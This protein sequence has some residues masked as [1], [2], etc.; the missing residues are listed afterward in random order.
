MA[1]YLLS[2]NAENMELPDDVKNALPFNPQTIVDARVDSGNVFLIKD[3]AEEIPLGNL[4]GAPGKDGSNVVPTAQAIAAV[5]A[6]VDVRDY[7]QSGET[8]VTDGSAAGN[9]TAIIQRAVNAVNALWVADGRPRQIFFPDGTYWLSDAGSV[10]GDAAARYCV[11]WMS[12]VGI[13]TSSFR[14][15][16]F[17]PPATASAFAAAGSW[18]NIQDVYMDAH[19]VDGYKQTNTVVN[20]K[21]KG[22]FIQGLKNSHW[23]GP[24]IKNCFSTGW[25]NDY[26]Q[27]VTGTLYANGN[28]RG[29]LERQL[30]VAGNYRTATATSG[31]ATLTSSTI[32]AG[33]A[34]RPIT[35]VGIPAGTYVGTVVE[36]VSFKLTSDPFSQVDVL[37]TASG[38]NSYRLSF[39]PL[40]SSGCSGVGIGTGRFADESFDL[41]CYTDGNGFHGTF[42]ETQGSESYSYAA[43]SQ[44]LYVFASNNYVGFR[45]CGSNGLE[46][47]LTT[48]G[49][50]YAEVLHAKTILNDVL[51]TNGKCTVN[52]VGAA[53]TGILFGAGTLRGPYTFTGEIRNGAGNGVGTRSDAALPP[54]LTLALDIH[55]NAGAAV[56]L[57][58]GSDQLTVRV[59]EWGNGGKGLALKGTGTANDLT[60]SNSDFRSGGTLIEQTL[61]GDVRVSD[62]TRGIALSKPS[63]VIAASSGTDGVALTWSS[64]VLPGVT[65][66]VIQYRLGGATSWT[67]WAHTASATPA[68]TLT[69]LKKGHTYD[70]QVA[71]VTGST[72][73]DFTTIVRGIAGVA[74]VID[75]FNRASGSLAGQTAPDGT[76]NPTWTLNT[77]ASG[78]IGVSSS[79]VA[80]PTSGGSVVA[81]VPVSATVGAVQMKFHAVKTDVPANRRHGLVFAYQDATNYF[82][83]DTRPTSTIL[84]L[85]LRKSIAGTATIISQYSRPAVAG[86]VARIEF[87]TV[88]HR[89]AWYVNEEFVAAVVDADFTYTL[90]AGMYG[91]FTTDPLSSADDFMA[92]I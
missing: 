28:G 15:V 10:P 36:G 51:G 6:R 8:L 4:K 16:I 41:T 89:I 22:W 50:K 47:V 48:R 78:V 83:C 76:T 45:D 46:T 44:R 3:N 5:I 27:N 63:G 20:S 77:T 90:A 67:T 26:L 54:R 62:T 61:T 65:D 18:G 19:V 69:G 13:G 7:V 30:D 37:V 91:E 73:S 85:G 24:L 2:V 53:G 70:F 9:N 92:W 38:S 1:N 84:N 55:D 72:T 60:I 14:G 11:R 79:I 74:N 59:R 80:K 82:R 68:A 58:K 64:P 39:D 66:Y 31:S 52:L 35:G 56:S 33:D 86:D 49:N 42:T 88:T 17:V 71:S 75:R 12:G 57:D 40:T 23:D 32:L 81:T 87:D 21:Y 29:M 34:K 43:G 25:G